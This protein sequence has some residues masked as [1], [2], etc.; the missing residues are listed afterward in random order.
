MTVRYQRRVVLSLSTFSD[1]FD[2]G[3]GG[4]GLVQARHEAA[5]GEPWVERVLGLEEGGGLNIP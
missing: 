3:G 1:T 2:N 5:H 4:L